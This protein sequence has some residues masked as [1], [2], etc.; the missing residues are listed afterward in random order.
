[1]LYSYALKQENF[2][3]KKSRSVQRKKCISKAFD[4]D[5]LPPIKESNTDDALFSS[6]RR[7]RMFF[8][9]LS[10]EDASA[11]NRE[12]PCGARVPNV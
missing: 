8:L 6:D 5:G 2:S 9:L 1:M 11:E 12:N 4:A 10:V 3:L 7:M